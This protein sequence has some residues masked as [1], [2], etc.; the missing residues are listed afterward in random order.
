MDVVM[1]G[2]AHPAQVAGLLIGLAMKGERPAELVGLARTMRAR[3][4]RHR[5]R[6]RRPST[7]AAPAATAPA[8]S[9]SRRPRRS[10]SP[11]PACRS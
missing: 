9:T 1:H 10:S 8:R 5:R 7:P 2:E 6:A 3:G 4:V 11:A